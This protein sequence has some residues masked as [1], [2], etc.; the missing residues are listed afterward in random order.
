MKRVY[1]WPTVCLAV[2]L[3]LIAAVFAFMNGNDGLA[4]A[5]IVVAG[6]EAIFGAAMVLFTN[7][8]MTRSA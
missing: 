7:R 8:R 5:L 1:T 2:G 3:V 6:C 4:I